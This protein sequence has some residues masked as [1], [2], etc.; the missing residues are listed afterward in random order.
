MKRSTRSGKISSYTASERKAEEDN[1]DLDD[2]E[3]RAAGQEDQFLHVCDA[4]PLVTASS[5]VVVPIA[6]N[7]GLI[8][9]L[10]LRAGHQ[11]ERVRG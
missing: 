3:A 6:P 10:L 8:V 7:N 2:P 1:G 5:G 9:K 4:V 11:D